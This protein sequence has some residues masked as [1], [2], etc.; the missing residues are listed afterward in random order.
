MSSKPLLDAAVRVVLRFVCLFPVFVGGMAMAAQQA[1]PALPAAPG[2]AYTGTGAAA[3][4]APNAASSALSNFSSLSLSWGT[5]F[6]ALAILCFILAGLWALLWMLKRHGKGAF[7][8]SGA[9]TMRLES[10]LA[11]GPKKWIMVVRY[12]D[13]RLLLGVTD[14]RISM[15]TE[16]PLEE[17]NSAE[18]KTAKAVIVDK[19]I[20]APDAAPTA[21]VT[22]AGN[23][24][25]PAEE[26]KREADELFASLLRAH[27]ENG[28]AAE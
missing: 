17:D 14:D 15:L 27:K 12:L 4:A 19:P 25:A 7:F 23:A 20:S 6:E 8:S 10:R 16:I 1:D 21:N 5:Y 2:G 26:D 11:L 18:K 9:P 28:K 13:R 22:P 3:T 24:N